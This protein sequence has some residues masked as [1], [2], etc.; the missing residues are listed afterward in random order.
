MAGERVLVVD[1]SLVYRDLLVIHVLAPTV[2]P[3]P[4]ITFCIFICHY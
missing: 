1:D 3:F 2:I 4:R